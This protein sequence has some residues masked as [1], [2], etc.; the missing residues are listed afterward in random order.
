MDDTFVGLVELMGFVHD[1]EIV[2]VENDLA[3]ALVLGC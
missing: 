1:V 2:V 3:E